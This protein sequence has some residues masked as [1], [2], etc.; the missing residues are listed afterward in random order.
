MNKLIIWSKD[1]PCQLELLLN[2]ISKNYPVFDSIN[3]VFTYTNKD[4]LR[5]YYIVSDLYPSVRFYPEQDRFG[6]EYLTKTLVNHPDNTAV[7]FSTD[8]TVVYRQNLGGSHGINY[9]ECFTLRLGTNTIVQNCH[10]GELQPSLGAYVQEGDVILW[11]PHLCDPISNYGYCFGLD[12]CGYNAIHMQN[13]FKQISFK[14]PNQLESWLFKFRDSI[15]VMK[16]Y[17]TSIAVNIPLNN[18]SGITECMKGTPSLEELNAEFLK[19]K[20]IR[21]SDVMNTVI[22]G[23]HQ[24]V[25]L[26]LC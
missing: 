16:S 22:L 8:D 23:A 20:R 9:G 7:Y 24:E 26:Q 3:V 25:N 14:N 6:F 18:M 19:G 4:F 11:N 15:T 12:M 2:S 1:R 13:I 10:T 17:E 5:G 21:L